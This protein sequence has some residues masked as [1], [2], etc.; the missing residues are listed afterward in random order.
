M[1]ND[2]DWFLRF[3]VFT[4]IFI[5]LFGI[6][7]AYNVGAKS[8]DYDSQT[9]S[10]YQGTIESLNV[11]KREIFPYY[12]ETKKCKVLVQGKVQGKWYY[13]SQDY[14]FTPDMSENEACKNAINKAKDDLLKKYVPE[15][16]ESK[17]NLNCQVLTN[18]RIECTIETLNVVMPGLGLQEVKLKQCNR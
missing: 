18:P 8:C 11:E 13:T 12:Q 5:F 2:D 1:N 15:F 6:F 3:I 16:I 4:T 9:V 7:T 17:E 10:T 14:I